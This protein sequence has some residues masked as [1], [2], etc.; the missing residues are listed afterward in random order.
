MLDQDSK[1][2]G[3]ANPSRNEPRSTTARSYKGTG[4]AD[5]GRS[6]PLSGADSDVEEET[7][8]APKM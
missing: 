1:N 5:F 7:V 4:L 6:V 8:Y 2:G 3:K